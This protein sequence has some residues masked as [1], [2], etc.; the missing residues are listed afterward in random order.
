METSLSEG[1]T[2]NSKERPEL[3]EAS[4]GKQARKAREPSSPCFPHPSPAR[5]DLLLDRP[6]QAGRGRGELL[7]SASGLEPAVSA[8]SYKTRVISSCAGWD[9]LT[10]HKDA[11]CSRSS[12]SASAGSLPRPRGGGGGLLEFGR[13][14]LVLW[15][16]EIAPGGS[17]P[18]S[19]PGS[20]KRKP[21]GGRGDPQNWAVAWDVLLSCNLGEMAHPLP[22][23]SQGTA[24]TSGRGSWCLCLLSSLKRRCWGRGAALGRSPHAGLL[25]AQSPGLSPR[26]SG[27]DGCR[28]RPRPRPR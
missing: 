20:R 19:S 1:L 27:W 7:P 8:F 11:N 12:F 9:L 23:H 2:N 16:S 3:R 17:S 4:P 21:T 13:S 18:A 6:V 10:S 22:Q 25:L 28:D 15:L 26:T 5:T 24:S 14:S